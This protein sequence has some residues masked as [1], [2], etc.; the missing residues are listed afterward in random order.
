MPNGS[1]NKQY[2]DNYVLRI[3]FNGNWGEHVSLEANKPQTH[4]YQLPLDAQ[5][6]T[7]HLS[8]V[9]FIYNDNGVEQAI[10]TYINQ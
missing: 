9:A 5:W 1:A 6:N 3:A 8:V 10:K 2:V 7:N 4:T